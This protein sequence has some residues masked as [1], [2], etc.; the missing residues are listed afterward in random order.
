MTPEVI[1]RAVLK[2]GLSAIAITDHNTIVGAE[3]L[4]AMAPFPVIVGEE[5][6]T[7]QGEIVGLFLKEAIP[8]GLSPQKTIDAIRGQDGLVYIP[9]PLDR[10]RGSPLAREVLLEVLDQVDILE[11]LNSRVLLS[12]DNRE[13]Q[14]L[15]VA[16]GI[17]QGAGSDAHSPN[18]IGRAFVAMPGFRGRHDFMD[19]LR[20]GHI[21][22]RPSPPWVH[23]NSTWAKQYKRWNSH[24]RISYG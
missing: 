16:R 13:A 3:R 11:T 10:A 23:M 12:V 8:P 20:R 15:A 21:G 1:I 6:R 24:R 9:H 7:T 4:A 14:R 2:R 19:R 5:I 22:G 17:V 18:E